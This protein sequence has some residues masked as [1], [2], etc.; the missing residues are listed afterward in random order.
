MPEAIFPGRISDS[1]RR[2]QGACFVG[3]S[4]TKPPTNVMSCL[5]LT[6]KF[7][8]NM[9]K[10]QKLY[11]RYSNCFKAKV[12]QEVSNGK[13]ISEVCRCYGI[14]GASTVQHRLKKYG[15]TDLLNTVIRVKMRSED[16][17]MKELESEVRRLKIALDDAVPAKDVP[18]CLIE[19]V[20]AHYGTD[21]KKFRTPAIRRCSES[22]SQS[23]KGMC[24]YFKYT[25][26]AY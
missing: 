7:R 22:N 20:D 23:V 26:A 13:S 11:Y 17:R 25:R 21:V 8:K 16:D 15:R 9:S 19:E 2:Y 10:N 14:I 12:V 6:L 18:E 3:R 5:R 4:D 24:R 1:K